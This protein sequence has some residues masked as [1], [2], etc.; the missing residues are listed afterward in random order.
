MLKSKELFQFVALEALII[1][2][3]EYVIRRKLY[4]LPNKSLLKMKQVM[5]NHIRMEEA[6]VL[7][8]VPPY[9]YKDNHHEGPFKQNHSLSKNKSSR[10]N[11]EGPTYGCLIYPNDLLLP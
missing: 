10:K 5:K 3:K 4:A 1:E 7:Q 8:Y 9:F 11:Y 2:V 6:I